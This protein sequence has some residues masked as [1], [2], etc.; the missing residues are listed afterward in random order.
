MEAQIVCVRTGWA[1]PKPR[2]PAQLPDFAQHQARHLSVREAQSNIPVEFHGLVKPDPV[3]EFL[4][5]SGTA[6]GIPPVRVGG[7]KALVLCERERSHSNSKLV[8][9]IPHAASEHRGRAER[10]ALPRQVRPFSRPEPHPVAN[11]LLDRDRYA[12]KMREY[13]GQPLRIANLSDERTDVEE[14]RDIRN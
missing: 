13:V 6:G 3:D 10:R 8:L 14:L 7:Q 4:E 9:A 11:E 5:R 12:K 2:R 1:D